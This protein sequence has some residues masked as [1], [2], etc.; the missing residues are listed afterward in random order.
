LSLYKTYEEAYHQ[1]VADIMADQVISTRRVMD[2][3]D[4]TRRIFVDGGFSNNAV[5]MNLLAASFTDKQVFAA[6]LHQASALGAALAIHTHWTRK[7]AP[8]HLIKLS[9]Q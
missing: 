5:F 9:E 4:R 3:D 1:L 8:L 7:T 6:S 2:K